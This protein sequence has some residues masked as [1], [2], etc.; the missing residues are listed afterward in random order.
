MYMLRCL[1]LSLFFVPALSAQSIFDS[2]YT[3]KGREIYFASGKADLNADARQNLDSVARLFSKGQLIRF[4][5]TAHTD[6]VGSASFNAALSTRRAAAVK[7]ALIERGITAEQIQIAGFGEQA[8]VSSNQTEDGRQRNRRATVEVQKPIPMAFLSGQVQDQQSGNGIK[9][10]LNFSSK[11]RRDSIQTDDRGFY[12]VRLPKDSLVKMEAIAK[13]H[14]FK[15]QMVKIFGTPE[16]YK[17]YKVETNV[18]LPLAK[19]GEKAILKDLFFVGDSAILL[20]SSEAQLPLVLKFMQINPDLKVEIAGH[21]NGP[22]LDLNMETSWRRSLSERRAKVVYN[23]LLEKGIS[24]DRMRYK[25]YGNKE[26]IYPRPKNDWESEQNR[27]VEIRVVEDG[28][29]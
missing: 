22:N 19:T 5:I 1:L 29:D 7:N 16:L 6:S 8:P 20:K 26:M 28:Q 10:T 27:R 18:S 3:W 21:I 2:L 11:N 17:K 13:D 23:Y 12:K 25:G 15:S 24:A 14:F 4:R 9:A